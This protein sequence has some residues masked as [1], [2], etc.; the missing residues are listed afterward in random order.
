MPQLL[1]SQLSLQDLVWYRIAKLLM[2]HLIQ[3]KSHHDG[4]IKPGEICALFTRVP[5]G[6]LGLGDKVCKGAAGRFNS[7][8]N[9]RQLR[10]IPWGG[11]AS[12]LQ[13][14]GGKRNSQGWL[15]AEG[16]SRKTQEEKVALRSQVSR[17]LP[18]GSWK[19]P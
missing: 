15:Q 9:Q 12:A 6:L 1:L 14:I 13:A 3:D 18:L 10:T 8:E 4:F 17:S 11:A 5:G 19:M 16:Y 2:K 7:S